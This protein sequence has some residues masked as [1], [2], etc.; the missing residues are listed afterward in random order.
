MLTFAA[1]D[2]SL[3]IGVAVF[4]DAH[5][6]DEETLTLTLSN[7]S[8]GPLT[9]AEATGTIENA[10]P[11]PRA[12]LARFGRTAAVQMVEP[13]AERIE[14]RGEPGFCGRFGWPGGAAGDGARRRAP[15]PQPARRGDGRHASGKCRHPLSDGRQE[16]DE[17]Q[18]AAVASKAS[19]A[20]KGGS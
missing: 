19:T 7:A 1:G 14:A 6:E 5:D 13:V 10:D 9:D 18:R 12:V 3:T 2:P 17:A 8:G 20:S 11:L 16:A 15:V 4:D